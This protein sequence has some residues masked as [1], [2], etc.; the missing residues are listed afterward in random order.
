MQ[1]GADLN[2]KRQ[3]VLGG[4]LILVASA[5]VAKVFGAVFRIPLTAMLG[6][7]GMGYFSTAY[8]LFLPIFTLSVTGVNTAVAALTAR[9]LSSGDAGGARLLHRRSLR[10]FGGI[11]FAAA[12]ML[13]LFAEPICTYL[14]QNRGAAWAVRCFAPAVFFC[15]VNA[16][17]RGAW[18]GR[19]DMRPTAVSQAAESAARLA[20]G[21]FLCRYVLLHGDTLPFPVTPQTRP[22]Y[23]AAAAILGV[24]G[25]TAVGTAVI[26]CCAGQK[27]P[28][29]P[30]RTDAQTLLHDLWRLIL[31]IS[32]AALVTN[33]TSL[34][35]LTTGMQCLKQMYQRDFSQNGF[36]SSE[37][38]ANFM[39]GAFS[40]MSVTVF[41]L[42]PSIVNML[43]KGV[44]PAFSR[45]Y[46]Q[47]DKA[48]MKSHAG[49]VLQTTALLAMPSGLGIFAMS[50]PILTFL[51]PSRPMEVAAAA[52]PLMILGLAV[53]VLC[54]SVP[55]MS[56]LQAADFASQSAFLMV[57][58]AAAKLLC[59]L[60]LIPRL[61]LVGMAISTFVCYAVILLRAAVTFHRCIGFSTH[62]LRFCIKPLIASALCAVSAFALYP[63]ISRVMPQSAT[64]LISVL[65][66]GIVYCISL[67]CLHIH[68]LKS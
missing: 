64:L 8:G 14:L 5:M 52:A 51:F 62:L 31:P 10:M 9:L 47:N 49:A 17:L 48:A 61:G 21:L 54:L 45:A 12:L 3:T 41:N 1:K 35:D 22:M 11:G 42:V 44:L 40:G 59:N 32:A 36:S 2:M 67:W 28:A 24:S 55:L 13:Y 15:S 4:S 63:H 68:I 58:G 19:E 65:F 39:Y 56:M 29:P 53:I 57:W 37:A 7:E 25:S 30:T 38:A 27:K 20:L 43:G 26:L 18:E 66:G 6:G 16:V 33:L 50:S 34:V 46:A 60:L 23:A